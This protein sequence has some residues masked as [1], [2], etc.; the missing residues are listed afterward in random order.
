LPVVS[1]STLRTRCV[2]LAHGDD[3]GRARASCNRGA[4]PIA[5]ASQ[6]TAIVRRR[7]RDRPHSGRPI[8][9][10]GSDR[11]L[12]L[13]RT[14]RDPQQIGGSHGVTRAVCPAVLTRRTRRGTASRS[15]QRRACARSQHSPSESR[16]GLHTAHQMSCTVQTGWCCRVAALT[17]QTLRTLQTVRF[18]RR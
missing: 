16:G 17:L 1:R 15:S 2:I 7:A 11:A 8:H 18:T 6:R 9:P 12:A 3:R 5:A 14:A 10:D 4:A 13:E